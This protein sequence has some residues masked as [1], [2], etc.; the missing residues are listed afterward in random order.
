MFFLNSLCLDA[1]PQLGDT[2]LKKIVSEEELD[3]D[4]FGYYKIRKEKERKLLVSKIQVKTVTLAVA[5]R[6]LEIVLG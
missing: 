2:K 4:I 1:V 6:L 3:E 5:V